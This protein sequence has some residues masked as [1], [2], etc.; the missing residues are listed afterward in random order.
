V[1]LETLNL[2]ARSSNIKLNLSRIRTITSSSFQGQVRALL[3]LER[4]TS[5]EQLVNLGCQAL[6][7][8]GSQTL[9]LAFR[10]SP[11]E[12]QSLFLAVIVSLSLLGCQCPVLSLWVS[13]SGSLSLGV[14]V[15]F[16]LSL[17]VRFSHLTTSLSCSL[18][19]WLS[20]SLWYPRF[21]LCSLF[22]LS[23]I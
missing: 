23:E 14:C 9:S 18:S 10:F 12:F 11:F 6:S 22:S 16:S 3:L 13:V 4:S 2:Y 19:C 5:Y 20:A 15:R 17:A 1:L 21:L 7:L 8:L